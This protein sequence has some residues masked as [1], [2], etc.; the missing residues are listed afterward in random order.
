[1]DTYRQKV[2]TTLKKITKYRPYGKRNRGKQTSWEDQVLKGIKMIVVTGRLRGKI[3]G[4]RLIDE[5]KRI[6]MP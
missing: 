5:G 3:R 6:G 1:M 2:K 4:R